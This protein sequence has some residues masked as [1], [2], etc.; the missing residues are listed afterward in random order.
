M[1]RRILPPQGSEGSV[2]EDWEVWGD[3][4]EVE[5]RRTERKRAQLPRETRLQL[6]AEELAQ[7]GAA[8]W[9]GVGALSCWAAARLLVPGLGIWAGLCQAAAL[10][11][12]TGG[13]KARRLVGV[14]G[15]KLLRCA[16]LR[17]AVLCCCAGVCNTTPGWP[18]VVLPLLRGRP[19]RRL[20]GPRQRETRAG[21]GRRET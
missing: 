20:R 7:V 2:I 21:S 5:R 4:R 17:C 11:G 19:R 1:P 12:T 18:R 8:G 6:I 13:R 3:P 15:Q 16:A 10:Y 14:D 9:A